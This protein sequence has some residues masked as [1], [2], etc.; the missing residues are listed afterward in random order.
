MIDYY[1]IFSNFMLLWL[2]LAAMRINDKFGTLLYTATCLLVV[3]Y[4]CPILT[5]ATTHHQANRLAAGRFPEKL[6]KALTAMFLFSLF[7]STSFLP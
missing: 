7:Y 4:W 6:Q 5:G 2:L 3:Y 1:H